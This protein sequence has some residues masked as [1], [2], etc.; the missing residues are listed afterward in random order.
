MPATLY[1]ASQHL[2]VLS[3]IA[4]ACGSVDNHY[5]VA[6]NTLELA[7]VDQGALDEVMAYVALLY[8]DHEEPV[9]EPE[10]P[11]LDMARINALMSAAL[12]AMNVGEG[13]AG[14]YRWH[15]ADATED[16]EIDGVVMDAETFV[17]WA[18]ER[19]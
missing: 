6:T 16:F 2:E 7:D 15:K 17:R 3:K 9:D 4:S 12:Y 10:P 1:N 13:D 14:N 5:R 18:R 8:D 11:S 19:L